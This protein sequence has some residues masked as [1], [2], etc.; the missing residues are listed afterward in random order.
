MSRPLRIQFDGAWYHVMNRGVNRANIFFN[1]KHRVEFFKVLNQAKTVY[2][3]EIHAYCLMNNH[4]HLIIHTPRGN[5]SQ[6][7]KY[8]NSN[9]ARFVNLTMRRDGPLFK[10]RFK[11]IL[12][13]E[14]DYLIR[15]SRYIHR[16]PSEAKMVSTLSSYKWSSYSS[17]LGITE[18]PTWLSTNEITRRFGEVGFSKRYKDYVELSCDEDIDEFYNQTEYQPVLGADHFR[19]MIDEYV[20]LHSLSA[21]IIGADNILAPPEMVSIIDDVSA[22]FNVQPSQIYQVSKGV[23]NPARRMAIYICRELGG[24]SLNEIA[25]AMGGVSYKAI[26]NIIQKVKIDSEQASLAN[27]IMEDI[28]GRAKTIREQ[29]GSKN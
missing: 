21:D 2:G 3:I 14:D 20:K 22:Y 19:H 29:Q 9:Y 6:A 27:Q 11:A 18:K 17:Y 25:S 12:I 26:S 10:G 16:N 4:Y 24:V 7:M 15:L 8:I 28:W 13:G 1:T 5:I 23:S